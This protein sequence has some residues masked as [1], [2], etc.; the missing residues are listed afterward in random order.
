M[1]DRDMQKSKKPG[2]ENLLPI[3]F[4]SPF[5][6]AVVAFIRHPIPSPHHQN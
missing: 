3:P 6:R 2:R 4:L 1:T 5:P